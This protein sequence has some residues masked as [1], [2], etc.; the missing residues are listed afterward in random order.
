MATAEL[1]TPSSCGAACWF[2]VRT[3]GPQFSES[4]QT[5]RSEVL[6]HLCEHPGDYKGATKCV[7]RHLRLLW[8]RS[9]ASHIWNKVVSLRLQENVGVLRGDFV[10]ANPKCAAPG[11]TLQVRALE[12][13]EESCTPLTEVM[14]PV[15]G[16]AAEMPENDSRYLHE[17]VLKEMGLDRGVFAEP[18]SKDGISMPGGYRPLICRPSQMKVTALAYPREGSGSSKARLVSTDL[19]HLLDEPLACD[20]RPLPAATLQE[21]QADHLALVLE[22]QLPRSSYATMAIRELLKGHRL[23]CILH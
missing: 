5:S 15:L 22:F 19:D 17:R 12:K 3:P 18:E 11:W 13:G 2:I 20:V 10:A 7:P 8:C 16:F 4:Y 1:L 6:Q 21:L 9:V 14:V 23:Q